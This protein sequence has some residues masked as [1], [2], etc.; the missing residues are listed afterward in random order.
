MKHAIPCLVVIVCLGVLLSIF[1][2]MAIVAALNQ[3]DPSV[4]P[5]HKDPV[6]GIFTVEH[7]GHKFVIAYIQNHLTMV[8]HP[9]DKSQAR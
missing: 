8:V 6:S 5:I 7:D 4:T 2:K 1:T 9:D 3:D